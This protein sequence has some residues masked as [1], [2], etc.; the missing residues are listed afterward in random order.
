MATAPERSAARIDCMAF[1][2]GR[3]LRQVPGGV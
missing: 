1:D 3:G 2:A